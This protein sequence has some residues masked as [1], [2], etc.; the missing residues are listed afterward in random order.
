MDGHM[1]RFAERLAA[2][3]ERF[4]DRL[5]PERRELYARLIEKAPR[6]GARL[7]SRRN[8]TIVHGDAHAWNCLLPRDGASAD[9]RFFDWDSWRL[10]TA[11]DDLAYMMALHWYPDRRRRLERPLLDVYH[12]ALTAHGVAGY[13]RQA[14]QDDYRLSVLWQITTP[15]WQAENNIP[16]VIWWNNLERIHL[17]ADDLRCRDLLA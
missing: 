9:V 15:V 5:P 16:P 8:L 11:T 12:A 7:L 14:L 17:A 10:D 4:G 2:F 6:L 1:R 13:D 3:A